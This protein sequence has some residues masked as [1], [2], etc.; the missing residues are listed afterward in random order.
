[1]DLEYELHFRSPLFDLPA[2]S[3]EML[4]VLHAAVSP[5]T[6]PSSSDMQVLGGTWLSDLRIGMNLF[7]GK[8]WL[9]LT[10]DQLTMR[11]NRMQQSDHLGE[12][13]TC[14]AACERALQAALPA[15]AT[16]TAFIKATL[17]LRLD[18]AGPSAGDHL[19]RVAGEEPRVDLSGL[20]TA[21]LQRAIALDI[22]NDEERWEAVFDAY[23]SKFDEAAMTATCRVWHYEGAIRQDVDCAQGTDGSRLLR[24]ALCAHARCRSW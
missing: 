15:A 1:M 21:T 2:R 3:V 10:A 13:R 8:A 18:G 16:R 9:N 20:G 22:Q 11:F 4:Q 23:R 14:I 19:A 7:G 5:L 6:E 12:C 17:S 24:P